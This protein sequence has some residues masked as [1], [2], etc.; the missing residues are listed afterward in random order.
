MYRLTQTQPSMQAGEG[1]E[2]GA[3]IRIWRGYVVPDGRGMLWPLA[4]ILSTLTPTVAPSSLLLPCRLGWG[5]GL[6]LS[7]AMEKPV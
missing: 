2:S 1:G 4:G 5:G 6:R 7:P 3:P